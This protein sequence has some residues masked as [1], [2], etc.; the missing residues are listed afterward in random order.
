MNKSGAKRRTRAALWLRDFPMWLRALS[1]SGQPS[2]P[3]AANAELDQ[4]AQQ[5]AER[6]SLLNHIARALSTTL[7]LDELLE[8][9][10]REITAGIAADT[11]FIALYDPATNEM[12]FR[13]QVDRG[14][15]EPPVRRSLPNGLISSVITHK[16]PILIRDL[17][18]EK[19]YQARVSL[20]GTMLAP[21]S[22]LGVPMLIGDE[23]VGAISVQAYRP[24]AYG[25]AEQELLSTIAD[26]VAVAIKNA[27][28]YQE[29]HQYAQVMHA[30]N[31][32][33]QKLTATLNV[34]E[35]IALLR[36]DASDLLQPGNFALA[37]HDETRGDLE[38]KLYLDHGES[39][40][41]FRFDLGS[42][43]VS[44][45]IA[46]R[47][48][49]IAVDYQSECEKRGVKPILRDAR[50]W[51]GVPLVAREKVLGALMVWD[52]ERAGTLQERDQQVLS[53]LAAQAAIA[54]D[55]ARLYGLEHHARQ[56]A[57]LLYEMGQ[58]FSST[59]DQQKVVEQ[60]SRRCSQVLDVDLV[61]LRLIEG[62]NLVLRG[63]FFRHPEEE[64]EVTRL[65][66]ENPIHVGTGIAGRVAQTGE[67]A[68]SGSAPV[69]SLTLPGF[70]NFLSQ[71]QW[72]VV[73]LK[74][75][76]A[77]I[78]V[79]TF[80]TA[81]AARSFS[82]R[83]VA[84]AQGIANQA[85]IALE[86]AR[87]FEAEQSRRAEAN[88]L[89]DLSRALA[90]IPQDLDA[91][92]NLVTRHAVES[93]R[94]T[95]ARVALLDG[96]EFVWRAAYPVRALE[97]D[98]EVGA[99][100]PTSALSYCRRALQQNTPVVLHS[101]SPDLGEYERR[102]LFGDTARTLCLV[103][104]LIGDPA[105]FT[106]RSGGSGRA[107][108]LLLLGEARRQEREPFG[109][110]KLRLAR[111]IADQA[112]SAL[113]RAELFAELE[114][115]Y[116]QTV[117]ALANAVDAKDNYTADHAL[118]LAESAT[119]VGRALGLSPREL[120]EL[121]YGAIL[122]DIG[123]IGVSDSILKKPAELD[124]GEWD[125]MRQ[126]PKIGAEILIPV[127]RLQGPA[128]IVRHHH[129]RYDGKGYPDGLVGEA[130]PLGARILTVVDAFSA[131]VDKRV[132]KGARSDE[133]GVAELQRCA[134]TQFD[135]R[136]VETFLRL[137]EHGFGSHRKEV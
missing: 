56:V 2:R 116:L 118:R 45:V 96:E 12:D 53:T 105:A 42:A 71:R 8:V 106:S 5:R 48:P 28:L 17:E 73:P 75:K 64:I 21:A 74:V 109:A 24:N 15:R 43:L 103:P 88:A 18:Q 50:A 61:L 107:L 134:G 77:V 60:I 6:L 113:H 102:T 120:L 59:L 97:H 23:V 124:A 16:Q 135:P 49:I 121:R 13:V 30:L 95:F 130:I 91:I 9:V 119:A 100:A 54:I 37:L 90:D 25:D 58:L 38:M 57:S 4:Q 86:N 122:H 55:N 123:K 111:S 94:I 115:A 68:M 31:Q 132:Y 62:N 87:L 36:R 47:E 33:G 82:P 136:V 29:A 27:Q 19:E 51:L 39:K 20:W 127:A 65:L 11:F 101:A 128:E 92:L 1:R 69:Q 137:L 26:T 99:R 67:P 76:E 110:E 98:L 35:V 66:Q 63:S 34:D 52:N 83:D 3:A 126:H 108:G 32:I 129:E 125:Q 22:Y 114:R 80:I 79:L 10:Y 81:D 40:K 85:A 104:L 41:S 46:N 93:V 78:G 70:V 117:L 112:A 44:Q 84:L 14:V 72:L 133:E 89:Y 131:I 7:N